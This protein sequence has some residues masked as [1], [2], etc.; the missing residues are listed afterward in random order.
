M[1]T[2]QIKERDCGN[3][4]LS[5]SSLGAPEFVLSCFAYRGEDS[6]SWGGH[7]PSTLAVP[8]GHSQL[9]QLRL[10]N[11][12]FGCGVEDLVSGVY[13]HT[14]KNYHKDNVNGH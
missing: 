3:A 1:V 14:V 10:M 5:L 12:F 7:Q 8:K 13:I 2:Q 9:R 11:N 6:V 4:A